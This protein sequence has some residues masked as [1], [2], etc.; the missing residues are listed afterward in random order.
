MARVVYRPEQIRE[1]LM[2]LVANDGNLAKTT[3]EINEGGW[4]LKVDTLRR[5]RE[6]YSELYGDLERKADEIKETEIVA[7]LRSRIHRA[8]EI[9]EDLLERAGNV[10]HSR[11][12]PTALKAVNDVKTK[13]I[14]GLLKMTGR[15]QT[16]GN[17]ESLESLVASM[18][19][20]GYAKL[21]VN[22]E[23]EAPKHIDAEAHAAD[24]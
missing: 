15:D 8:A 12:I 2:A 16:Q 5:W 14:D 7:M 10:I 3:R 9:E 1:A 13:S 24:G 19:A 21:T 18:E 20:R 22:L 17:S 11:D 23:K 4:S 6:E